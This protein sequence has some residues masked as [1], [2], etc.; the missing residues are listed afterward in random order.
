MKGLSV[1][2]RD[3]QRR[4]I[5]EEQC[6]YD[7]LMKHRAGRYVIWQLQSLVDAGDG[8]PGRPLGQVIGRRGWEGE[9]AGLLHYPILRTVCFANSFR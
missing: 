4:V 5:W 7:H 6:H 8:Q 3:G 2:G 9:G 1:A